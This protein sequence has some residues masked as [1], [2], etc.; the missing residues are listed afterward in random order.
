[1]RE[2]SDRAVNAD[3]VDVSFVRGMCIRWSIR[4]FVGIT[5]KCELRRSESKRIGFNPLGRFFRVAFVKLHN[6]V[7]VLPTPDS[8]CACE[9]QKTN[10][11]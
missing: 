8:Y 7:Y 5:Y 3:H 6:M 2:Y 10:S 4:T 1:M 9:S 11:R